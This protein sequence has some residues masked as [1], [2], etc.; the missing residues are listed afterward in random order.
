MNIKHSVDHEIAFVRKETCIHSLPQE[1]NDDDGVIDTSY[2]IWQV[3]VRKNSFVLT[4]ACEWINSRFDV[5]YPLITRSHWNP[6]Q[7]LLC[8][9]KNFDVKQRIIAF[10][11]FPDWESRT[12]G[13]MRI[14]QAKSQSV[15]LQ[16]L[17]SCY[18]TRTKRG[19]IQSSV[20]TITL[21]MS[22]FV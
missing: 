8:Q 21:L 1:M 9:V 11:I 5:S 13:K 3:S 12:F 22:G 19:C 6:T 10:C 2:L 18:E 20:K 7:S 17:T 15:I 4:K 16:S 14:Q